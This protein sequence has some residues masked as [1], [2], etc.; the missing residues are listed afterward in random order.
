LIGLW[1]RRPHASRSPVSI[2]A[3]SR[4]AQHLAAKL[5]REE[6]EIRRAPTAPPGG[7]IDIGYPA[8]LNVSRSFDLVLWYGPTSTPKQPMIYAATLPWQV[9]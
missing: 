9:S 3:T 6:E 1:S 7:V 2:P 5:R 4:P 8:V